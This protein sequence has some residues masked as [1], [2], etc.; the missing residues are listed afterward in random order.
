M[1][2]SG[3]VADRKSRGVLTA[4]GSSFLKKLHGLAFGVEHDR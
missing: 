3:A 1:G 2:C 4:I